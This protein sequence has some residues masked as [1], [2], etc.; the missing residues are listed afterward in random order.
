[1]SRAASTFT[2][3]R[4]MV[5]EV[6]AVDSLE[7]LPRDSVSAEEPG[8]DDIRETRAELLDGGLGRTEGLLG[9]DRGVTFTDDLAVPVGRPG[10]RHLD[11]PPG[12]T[13]RE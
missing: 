10:P 2:R 1:M 11:V 12:R 5:P 4:S 7:G 9:L 8:A 3:P 6:R 13:A